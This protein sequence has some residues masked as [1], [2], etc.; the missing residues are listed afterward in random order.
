MAFGRGSLE[1][2]GV[3]VDAVPHVRPKSHR[4]VLSL[5]SLAAWN[6]LSSLT[7]DASPSQKVVLR[8]HCVPD[9]P[10][11]ADSSSTSLVPSSLPQSD[12]IDNLIDDL[13]RDLSSAKSHASELKACT[14][15]SKEQHQLPYMEIIDP[16]SR[17]HEWSALVDAAFSDKVDPSELALSSTPDHDLTTFEGPYKHTEREWL[18]L[19][20]AVLRAGRSIKKELPRSRTVPDTYR[21]AVPVGKGAVRLV[22]IPKAT[23]QTAPFPWSK[24][25]YT[26]L[27]L[28][29]KGAGLTVPR[30]PSFDRLSH[31]ALPYQ[32]YSEQFDP[33]E[34]YSTPTPSASSHD[35]SRSP[36]SPSSR[37][38]QELFLPV[39]TSSSPLTSPMPS[40]AVSA[41]R[42]TWLD[43]ASREQSGTPQSGRND[44][45]TSP[46]GSDASTSSIS[47]SKARLS[48]PFSGTQRDPSSTANKA[49]SIVSSTFET[50]TG[51]LTRR[52]T[53]ASPSTPPRFVMNNSFPVVPRT[54][55]KPRRSPSKH[56]NVRMPPPRTPTR[57]LLV[58]REEIEGLP[59][60]PILRHRPHQLSVIDEVPMPLHSNRTVRRGCKTLASPSRP[61]TASSSVKKVRHPV[62]ARAASKHKR[63]T[64]RK[65]KPKEKLQ[66]SGP[67]APPSWIPT[68]VRPNKA[69]LET[70]GDVDIGN[71]EKSVHRA[72][73]VL[74]LQPLGMCPPGAWDNTLG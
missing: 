18:H 48:D 17:V 36:L 2:S 66:I 51:V 69:N 32:P 26:G 49:L 11:Q 34:E 7:T 30:T 24:S 35:G 62:F 10:S 54:T 23:G 63:A 59:T 37:A 12:K 43:D 60:P 68:I 58:R 27:G 31:D 44:R 28:A 25:D 70:G 42:D 9:T 46:N 40:P 67:I 14:L 57:P 20:S 56:V 29:H 61:G 4:S 65:E 1:K 73:K 53:N 71:G 8:V 3:K 19:E 38:E 6:Q 64:L 39:P 45:R 41:H 74:G 33:F 55:Y 47:V 52:I 21:E 13:L 22:N 15:A 50:N 16:I 5:N 72:S